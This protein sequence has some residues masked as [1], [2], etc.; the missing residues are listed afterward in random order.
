MFRI[1]RDKDKGGRGGERREEER[2]EDS[3]LREIRLEY[4]VPSWAKLILQRCPFFL[5]EG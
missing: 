3:L 1:D 2:R 4:H 5:N